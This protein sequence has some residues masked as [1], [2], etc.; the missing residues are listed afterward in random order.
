[1]VFPETTYKVTAIGYCLAEQLSRSAFHT[2]A[3]NLVLMHPWRASGYPWRQTTLAGPIDE[4][5]MINFGHAIRS[6]RR[7]HDLHPECAVNCC[8]QRT[9]PVGVY[10]VAG[11]IGG[12]DPVATPL[13]AATKEREGLVLPWV[14]L[15]SPPVNVE[16]LYKPLVMPLTRRGLW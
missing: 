7:E 10:K 2:S 9:R 13:N 12:L 15:L 11:L 1:M 8:G 6:C 3:P 4:Q 5:S 16:Q 14:D